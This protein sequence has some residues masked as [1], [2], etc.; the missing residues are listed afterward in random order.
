MAM[1]EGA[2]FNGRWVHLRPIVPADYEPLRLAELDAS[3]ISGF[4][5]RGATP[6]PDGWVDSL[7]AGVLAQFMVTRKETGQPVGTVAAY[8]ADYRAG[9]CHLAAFVF[10]DYQRLA[11]PLEG[12]QLFIR[13]LFM[14]F[15]FRKLYGTVVEDNLKQFAR[16]FSASTHE[17]GRL[18]A[19]EYINGRYVD[20]ITLAIYR[21]E[22]L[23]GSKSGSGLLAALRREER[24]QEEL[25]D[26]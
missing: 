11:W 20:S 24:K 12:A 6:S 1:A 9:T 7:W 26:E 25:A 2:V 3:V 19:H 18:K 5:H 14:T 16:T 4:R 8:G 10:P 22:W 17:E 13:Y 15:P 21:D 23:Q